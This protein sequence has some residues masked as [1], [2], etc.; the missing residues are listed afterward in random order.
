MITTRRQTW[1]R[2]DERTTGPGADHSP[3]PLSRVRFKRNQELP[4]AAE[5]IESPYDPEAR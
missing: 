1:Q 5:A 2:H 3:A 4:P